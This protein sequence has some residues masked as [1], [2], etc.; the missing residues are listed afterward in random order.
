MNT[1]IKD[2]LDDVVR[3]VPFDIVTL[4]K[5]KIVATDCELLNE[6]PAGMVWTSAHEAAFQKTSCPITLVTLN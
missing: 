5:L 1:F 2:M 4:N 6:L 3:G